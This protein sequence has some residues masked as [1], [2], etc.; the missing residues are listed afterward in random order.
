MADGKSE[1][2]YSQ[3]CS[4]S[5]LC[6]GGAGGAGEGV[7]HKHWQACENGDR[8]IWTAHTGSGTVTLLNK[9]E[10]YHRGGAAELNKW[11]LD[12]MKV[13]STQKCKVNTESGTDALQNLATHNLDCWEGDF[14]FSLIGSIYLH[15]Q[16][17]RPRYGNRMKVKKVQWNISQRHW[18][19]NLYIT[20]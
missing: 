17:L 9:Y 14:T 10:K 12:A 5:W 19:R 7:S 18:R 1:I 15:F 6:D 16:M 11:G 2:S 13:A 8:R 20:E 4:L 3:Y